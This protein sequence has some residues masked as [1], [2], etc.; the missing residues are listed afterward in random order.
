MKYGVS[1]AT[2]LGGLLSLVFMVACGAGGFDP[3]NQ[4]SSGSGSNS[5]GPSP[6]VIAPSNLAYCQTL[7][8]NSTFSGGTLRNLELGYMGVTP[9]K[10]LDFTLDVNSNSIK[11]V[12]NLDSSDPTYIARNEFYSQNV[13]NYPV[14]MEGVCTEGQCDQIFISVR[15]Y[16]CQKEI[17]QVGYWLQRHGINNNQS[18]EPMTPYKTLERGPGQFLNIRNLVTALRSAP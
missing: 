7:A 13:G 15:T 16:N 2:L 17:K 9:Q 3:L 14:I 1:F 18:R 4:E 5:V 10:T 12:M 8:D 6:G 11:G